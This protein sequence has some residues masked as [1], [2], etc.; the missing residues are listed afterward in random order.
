MSYSTAVRVALVF[1]VVGV[2]TT[3]ASSLF[4]GQLMEARNV[5]PDPNTPPV[6][7]STFQVRF[8]EILHLG[9]IP[10]EKNSGVWYYDYTNMTAR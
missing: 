1:V 7:P 5:W 3:E 2:F 8:D 6:W 4:G 10:L 9:P